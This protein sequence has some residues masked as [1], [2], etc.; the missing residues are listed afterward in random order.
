M[1]KSSVILVSVFSALLITA[2]EEKS[3]DNAADNYADKKASTIP[4][5]SQA[6]TSD[7]PKTTQIA[8]GDTSQTSLDWPGSYRGT[9]PCA[10][11][12]G[13]KTTLILKADGQYRLLTDY[14]GELD[15]R[16]D[17]EGKFSWDADGSKIKLSNGNQY[18]VGE[19]QLFML[20]QAGNRVTGPLADHYRLLKK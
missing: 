1:K 3:T 20:D 11:C 5:A 15:G 7:K 8:K 14:M 10:S 9:L 17:E 13:I 12:E 19:N 2:C 4:V 6:T 18:Q 16:F